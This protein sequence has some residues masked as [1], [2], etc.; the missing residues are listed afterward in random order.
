M[1]EGA[2]SFNQPWNFNSGNETDVGMIVGAVLG[3]VLG[4][5]LLVGV[6]FFLLK[7]SKGSVGIRSKQSKPSASSMA[8]QFQEHA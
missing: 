8:P 7:R 4:A 2:S 1:F 6:A 5:L 3:S